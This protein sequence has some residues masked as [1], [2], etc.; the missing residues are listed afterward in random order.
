MNEG[1]GGVDMRS[2]FLYEVKLCLLFFL[3]F[4]E[5][6]IFTGKGDY[7][8]NEEQPFHNSDPPFRVSEQSPFIKDK[9]PSVVPYGILDK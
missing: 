3:F 8:A 2:T 9:R 1:A 6:R 4:N 5:Y 7:S